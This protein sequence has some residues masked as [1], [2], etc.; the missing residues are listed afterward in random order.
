[1]NF[2]SIIFSLFILSLLS[3]CY[4]NVARTNAKIEKGWD[5]AA[6]GAAA[7]MGKGEGDSPDIN[8]HNLTVNA[9]LDL[10]YGDRKEDN[11]GWAV[12]AKVPLYYFFSTL[13]AYF[14]LP[15]SH[16]HYVGVGV[17]AGFLSS[18]YAAYSYYFSEQAYVTFTPRV[19]YYFGDVGYENLPGKPARKNRMAHV[20]LNPQVSFGIW[21]RDGTV[22][23][24]LFANYN[25]I[26]GD[27]A[28][29]EICIFD[30]DDNCEKE[31][32]R[33][34]FFQLGAQVRF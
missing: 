3:G 6:S 20:W 4:P 14:E 16:P 2:Q 29:F 5:I 25:R 28:D 24:S 10:Q 18:L 31:D 11:F 9:E 30:F 33:K 27:G 19:H 26:L 15:S 8:K 32:L 7:F 34:H 21:P 23:V 1:M 17:E 22:D 12:Q 13:D